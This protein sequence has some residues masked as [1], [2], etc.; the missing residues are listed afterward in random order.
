MC[1]LADWSVFILLGIAGMIDWKKREVPIWLLLIMSVVILFFGIFCE[2]VDIWYRLAGAL[3]GVG[4]FAVSK[5]T[6]EA[7]GYGDSWLILILGI[8]MGIL[9]VLQV[10][11]AASL[12][13][14]IF[15]IFY[16]WRHRWKRSE[17]LPFVPFLAIAYAGVMVV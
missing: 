6:K 11:F 17:T 2:E 9:D 5:F 7:V 13:A 3:L 14:A 1:R 15:A 4:F 8:H 16:L 10:L 12:M